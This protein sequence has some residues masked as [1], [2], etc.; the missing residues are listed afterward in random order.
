[1]VLLYPLPKSYEDFVDTLQH[2]RESITLCDVVGAFYSKEQWWRSK[3]K[4]VVVKWCDTKATSNLT[5]LIPTNVVENNIVWS[6]GLFRR[7][8]NL[9]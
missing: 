2:G 5:L 8:L 1:M 6:K 3:S 7:G 4:E 9:N